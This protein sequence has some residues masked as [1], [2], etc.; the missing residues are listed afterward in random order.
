MKKIKKLIIKADSITKDIKRKIIIPLSEK[1]EKNVGILLK[2]WYIDQYGNIILE[3]KETN[4]IKITIIVNFFGIINYAVDTKT[5][6]DWKY[7][8]KIEDVLKNFKPLN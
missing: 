7:K 1:I 8:V 6:E 3:Y 2:T 5:R 4:E